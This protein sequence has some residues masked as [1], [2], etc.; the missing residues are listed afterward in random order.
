MEINLENVM[1]DVTDGSSAITR[2][3]NDFIAHLKNKVVGVFVVNYVVCRR[4]FA[5]K[6]LSER[7][8]TSHKAVNSVVN[9]NTINMG[10][11]KLNNFHNL[12]PVSFSP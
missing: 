4:Q 8:H 1:P 5:L 7:L 3:Y 10:K 11:N 9:L 6:D 12:S 2:L